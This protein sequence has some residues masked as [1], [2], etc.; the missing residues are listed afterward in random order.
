M[1]AQ[2]ARADIAGV[3]HPALTRPALLSHIFKFA[4][5]GDADV[6]LIHVHSAWEETAIRYCPWMW[7]RLAQ[8]AGIEAA[9]PLDGAPTVEEGSQ[10]LFHHFLCHVL[11]PIFMPS[12][13]RLENPQSLDLNRCD[14]QLTDGGL[15]HLML[16]IGKGLRTLELSGCSQLTDA[17][18]Q[19][20]AVAQKLQTLNLSSCDSIT[21][22]SLMP[23]SST[24]PASRPCRR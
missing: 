23:A 4:A 16:S 7:E 2:A 10:H 8:S 15:G 1:A 9:T 14:T 22:P 21:R 6:N 24:W 11:A 3:P 20:L 17:S 12:L 13:S 19:H 18:L 5:R